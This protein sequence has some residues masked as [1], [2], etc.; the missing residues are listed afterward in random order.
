[1]DFYVCVDD[2]TPNGKKEEVA[3]DATKEVNNLC[4]NLDVFVKLL[5]ENL[6]AL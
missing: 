2:G 3:Y 5:C 6:M 4:V 1:M